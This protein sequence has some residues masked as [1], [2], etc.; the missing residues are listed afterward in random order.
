MTRRKSSMLH[1]LRSL[2]QVPIMLV[3]FSGM[4]LAA[5]LGFTQQT[6]R[7]LGRGMQSPQLKARA[8]KGY[9]PTKRDVFVCTYSKSGT[10]WAMQIAYQIAHNGQGSFDHIHDVVPWPEAPLPTI[11][12]LSDPATYQDAPSGMR[13]IK[14]H[15]ESNYVPY[16]P[17]AK[18]IVVV[19]D[20]KEIFVS[21]YFFSGGMLPKSTMIGVNEWL[22]LF[23]SKDFPY[24]SWAGHIAGY[25]PWRRYTNVLFLTYAEMKADHTGTVRRI[26]ALMDVELSDAVLALAVEKSSFAYMKRLDHKFMPVAPFPFDRLLGKP[27]MIRKGE[28]GGTAELL[29]AEKQKQIDDYMQS[30]LRRYQCDFPYAEVFET[31]DGGPSLASRSV[32]AN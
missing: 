24:G 13:V 6:F 20:P 27:S 21:S 15:L 18:Y 4:W 30:E 17:D 19:R 2:V 25:W 14:T 10:N 28:A 12:S 22:A 8:F 32:G 5:T 16:S 26:A 23:L 31:Q 9:Q 7:F 29:T 11:V 1:H 3:T